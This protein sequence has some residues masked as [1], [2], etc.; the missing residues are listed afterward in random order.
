M[1]KLAI[2][3]KQA[4]QKTN[5]YI[6]FDREFIIYKGFKITKLSE[7]SY[8]IEDVRFS[9]L[10]GKVSEEVLTLL[11]QKGFIEGVD[12]IG[13]VRDSKRVKDYKKTIETLYSRRKKYKKIFDTNPKLNDKRIKSINKKIPYYAFLMGFYQTRLNQFNI[14]YNE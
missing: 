5:K 9:N 11:S 10:Y 7:S 6:L 13:Y 12:Y 14:K 2:W 1:N 8:T 4:V 3:Y